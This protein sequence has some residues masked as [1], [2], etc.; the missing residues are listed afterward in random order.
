MAK[1]RTRKIRVA[2]RK[3]R[4]NRARARQ[5]STDSLENDTVDESASTERLSGK[6]GLTRHRTV[7]GV[8]DEG[9]GHTVLRDVD[10]TQCEAARVL[11]AIGA[12]RCDAQ[13]AGGEIIPCTIRRVLRTLL[14]DTR[15]A[16]AAGDRVLIRRMGETEGVIERVDPRSSVLARGSGQYQHVIVAN[17]DQ[18]VIVGSAADPSLKPPLIDRFI[19][20][21]TK[22]G[23]RPIVCINKADLTDPVTLQPIVGLYSRLGCEVLL[24]SALTGQGMQRLR[25]LLSGRETAFAGQSGVGKSSLLN[26]LQ[27]GLALETAEVSEESR[28]GRHTTRVAELL[29]LTGGGWVVDTPGVRQMELWDIAPEEV[30]A[31][32]IE[33]RPFLARCRFPDCT[34]THEIGCRVKEAVDQGLL[35]R[36][37]Y[38]SY[39]R[40]RESS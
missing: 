28:K 29:P 14:R 39:R 32:F 12:N 10:E 18:L 25:V 2:F 15:N 21:A 24:S 31:Y 34:H 33:L 17:V 30:E 4:Q 6:G 9:A 5:V 37:R 27:P 8:E 20:S 35:S 1:K 7:I 38:D 16:V 23:V 26:A 40:M 22:G 19:A 36:L 11:R 13:L 3:N